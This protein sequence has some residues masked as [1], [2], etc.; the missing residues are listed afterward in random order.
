MS[1]GWESSR[2]GGSIVARHEW[3][4]LSKM[5]YSLEDFTEKQR[6]EHAQRAAS[7]RATRYR[8]VP[9]AFEEEEDDEDD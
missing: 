8:R 1:V 5:A 7:Q 2:V 3:K 9:G 4:G 6:T